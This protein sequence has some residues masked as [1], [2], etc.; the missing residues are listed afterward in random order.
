MDF[1][2]K[3]R[4]GFILAVLKGVTD[5]KHCNNANSKLVARL[6]GIILNGET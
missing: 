3:R 5:N 4:G 1:L 2:F 6:S